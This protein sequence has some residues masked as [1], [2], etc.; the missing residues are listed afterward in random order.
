MKPIGR[1]IGTDYEALVLGQG[2]DHNWALR[3]KG[4]RQAAAM[5]SEQTGIE[6]K[7]YTDLPGM[8]FYTGNFIERENGKG[9]AIYG[10]RQGACFETQ[11]FPD[12]V[13][14]ANFPSS[15]CKAGQAYHTVTAYRFRT[16]DR[17]NG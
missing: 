5:Y 16:N 8:Q 13:H 1:E 11:F 10:K 12:A 6:M 14:H 3:G 4:Y 15:I 17:R 7:V 9:G 2:Y